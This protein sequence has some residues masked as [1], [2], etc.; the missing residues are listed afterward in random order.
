MITSSG[1]DVP[2]YQRLSAILIDDRQRISRWVAATCG[3]A[4]ITC[5]QSEALVDRAAA[6]QAHA[7]VL[8]AVAR[9][10]RNGGDRGASLAR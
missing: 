6:A 10:L 3:T 5:W 2:I 7:R 8:V 9:S 1:S 4:H